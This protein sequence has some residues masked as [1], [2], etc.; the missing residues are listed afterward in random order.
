MEKSLIFYI[1]TSLVLGVGCA[2]ALWYVHKRKQRA[3]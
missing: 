3:R 2:Y 1:V